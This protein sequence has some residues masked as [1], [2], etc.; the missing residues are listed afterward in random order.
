[1]KLN[2]S[3]L[4]K[5][6]VLLSQ[7]IGQDAMLALVQHSGGREI[8]PNR[9]ATRAHLAE[10]LGETA[11]ETLARMYR[12]TPLRVPQCKDA[13]R[14]AYQD[15]MRA[16]YDRRTRAGETSRSVIQDMAARPPYYYD[17]RTVTSIVNRPDSGGTVIETTQGSL[18]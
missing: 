15:D 8:F 14:I 10:I 11:A 1:V 12:S 16:E 5:N 4:P 6:A 7:I 3:H 13:L 2:L 17:W 9:A 18:F